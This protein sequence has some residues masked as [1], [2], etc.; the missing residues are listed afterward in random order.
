MVDWKKFIIGEPP[1]EEI[2]ERVRREQAQRRK[3][4]GEISIWWVLFGLGMVL[5]GI[6][7]ALG[8][9]PGS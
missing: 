8:G 6:W 7:L 5:K 9:G 4:K 3:D 1:S 2:R